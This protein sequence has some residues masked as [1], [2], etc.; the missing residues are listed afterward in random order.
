MYVPGVGNSSAV[1]RVDDLEFIYNEENPTSV[2]ELAN[3]V[4]IY[5]NPTTDGRVTV[6][7]GAEMRNGMVTVLNMMGQT[8]G[9]FNFMN[10]NK[11]DVQVDGPAGMYFVHI[12]TEEGQT[13][14]VRV[15]KN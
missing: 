4:S 1:L 13:T 12:A 9:Q 7:L 3:E 10:E 15:I 5:P 8:V 2:E 14:T 6:A 11:I